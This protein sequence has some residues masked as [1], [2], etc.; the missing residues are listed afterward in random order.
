MGTVAPV[1]RQGVLLGAKGLRV[2]GFRDEV[3]MT[4][5]KLETGLRVN[6]AGIPYTVLSR[7]EAIGFQTFGLL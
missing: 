6:S 4:P 1:G 5:T 3:T 7:I 2:L